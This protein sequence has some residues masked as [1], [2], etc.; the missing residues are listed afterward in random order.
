MLLWLT[1][2]LWGHSRGALGLKSTNFTF[3]KTRALQQCWIDMQNIQIIL[4]TWIIVL[5]CKK[6]GAS[7][8]HTLCKFTGCVTAHWNDV[9]RNATGP[10]KWESIKWTIRSLGHNDLYKQHTKLKLRFTAN[11]SGQFFSML[12]IN[13]HIW[14]LPCI[15]NNLLRKC[16]SII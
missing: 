16:C 10:W 11:F 9:C 13:H 14:L 12:I 6:I 7:L 2:Y 15:N 4:N 8:K 1:I 5:T 3:R